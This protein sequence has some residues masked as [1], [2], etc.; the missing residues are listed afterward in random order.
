MKKLMLMLTIFMTVVA[1]MA[2]EKVPWDAQAQATYTKLYNEKKYAAIRTY[3]DGV[4]FTASKRL[5]GHYVSYQ[6]TL[7]RVEG[8]KA[9][10]IETAKAQVGAY[11]AKIGLTDPSWIHYNVLSHLYDSI[12]DKQP[13]YDYY[14]SIKVP[15]ASYLP[16]IATQRYAIKACN[17]LKKF[18]EAKK[19]SIA[20]GDS[21]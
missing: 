18:D 9:S 10:S 6:P 19:I 17:A 11:A 2:A 20:I 14:K 15:Y 8:K 12:A 4:D 7:D 1:I 5:R 3:L 21:K 16:I 13:A